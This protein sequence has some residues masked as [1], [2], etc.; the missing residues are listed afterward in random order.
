MSV[1]LLDGDLPVS[2][3]EID[4]REETRLSEAGKQLLCVRNG[5]GIKDGHFIK[6]PK[7]NAKPVGSIFLLD[8]NNG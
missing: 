2:F 5:L 4:L 6:R 3:G 1:L 8:K 7:I